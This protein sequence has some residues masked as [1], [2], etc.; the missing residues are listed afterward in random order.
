MTSA[1][2]LTQETEAIL[3][4]LPAGPLPMGLSVM[5]SADEAGQPTPLDES[6]IGVALLARPLGVVTLPR[7]SALFRGDARCPE[8]TGVPPP[9]LIGIFSC[10]ETT[11]AN[12]CFTHKRRVRDEEFE[13]MYSN[14]RRRP[15]GSS[16][17]PLF[18]YLRAALRFAMTVRPTSEDEFDKITRRLARS[19]RT[20]RQSAISTNYFDLALAPLVGR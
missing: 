5:M 20:F 7:L 11:A 4:S 10:V 2:T 15:D 12:W 19:A 13:K 6:S 3:A 1:L 9:H 14:L 17:H 16:P 18:D 8:L